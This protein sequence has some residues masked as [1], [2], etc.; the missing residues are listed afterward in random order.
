MSNI[1]KWEFCVFIW[2]SWNFV[3]LFIMGVKGRW[4]LCFLIW[5]KLELWLFLRQCLSEVFQ[6]KLVYNLAVGHQFIPGLGDLD[7]SWRSQVCQNKL[8]NM[9][10]YLNVSHLR[11]IDLVFFDFVIPS[12]LS[13]HLCFFL[14]SQPDWCRGIMIGFP[15]GIVL[16]DTWLR[17]TDLFIACW[18]Q[19]NIVNDLILLGDWIIVTVKK[20][21]L[22]V[23]IAWPHCDIMIDLLTFYPWM[24][25]P[26]SEKGKLSNSI[27][28]F[29]I[30]EW[31]RLYERDLSWPLC[32]ID[33]LI[34]LELLNDAYC[35]KRGLVIACWAH[36]DWLFSLRSD[37]Q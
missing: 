30:I 15:T 3:W 2:L 10:L 36:Y 32:G 37:K 21:P 19:C 13:S 8:Q 11:M 17:K 7:L 24:T 4:L 12:S 20:I 25:Y 27:L 23:L 9:L 31:H 29:S 1:F 14:C 35:W 22:I 16:N 5:Q 34:W 28:L 18:L 26:D 33:D 6:T